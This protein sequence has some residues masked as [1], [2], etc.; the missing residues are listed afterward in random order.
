MQIVLKAMDPTAG[1]LIGLL[2]LFIG[3]GGLCWALAAGIRRDSWAY[4]RMF[5]W[6]HIAGWTEAEE[7][8]PQTQ[9]SSSGDGAASGGT[10]M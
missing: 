10:D 5:L 1:L 9:T 3:V 2:V 6:M 7:G 8:Q 4:D